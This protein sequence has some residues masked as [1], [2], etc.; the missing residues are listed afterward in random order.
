MPLAHRSR[1][2]TPRRS[3][4]TSFEITARLGKNAALV[5]LGT[6]RLSSE[7]ASFRDRYQ[8]ALRE[9]VEAKTKG[10]ATPPRAIAGSPKV[11]K[12]MEALKRSL[13]QDAGAGLKQTAA[14]R[15]HAH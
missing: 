10:L 3:S 8:D 6:T 15:T 9:V 13:A 12:L 2:K 11:I 14:N 5:K 4:I 1:R 7:P